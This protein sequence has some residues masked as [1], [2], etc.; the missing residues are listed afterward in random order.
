MLRDVVLKMSYIAVLASLVI[1]TTEPISAC[2]IPMFRYGL[3]AWSSEDYEL[4]VFHKGPMS[5][6]DA[7]IIKN[8]KELQ[9]SAHANFTLHTVD[10]SGKMSDRLQ[11]L[12]KSFKAP[13]LPLLVVKYPPQ[14]RSYR[15]SIWSGHL[16]EDAIRK[17]VDSPARQEIVKRIL[18]GD[19]AV[20]VLVESGDPTK[21]DAAAKFISEELSV[22][23]KELTLSPQLINIAEVSNLDAHIHFSLIG[24]SRDDPAEEVFID[25]LMYSERGLLEVKSSPIVFLVFARGRA[26][27]P[28]VGKGIKEKFIR[29]GC[30][31]VIDMWGED[32][33]ENLGV[34]L[35]MAVDWEAGIGKRWVDEEI[36]L[37]GST[38]LISIAKSD[39]SSDLTTSTSVNYKSEVNTTSNRLLRNIIITILA[40]PVVVIGITLI[41]RPGKRRRIAGKKGKIK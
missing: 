5:E 8:L 13:E 31:F 2:L 14:T 27:T 34:G 4:I 7:L 10:V 29:E 37:V 19:T 35:L 40:I 16:S 39:E 11:N 30:E 23:N 17:I 21:D 12:W 3:E 38:T 32:E 9:L 22:I 28:M 25:M 15:G 6:E 20:L 26:L 24:V 1:L 36:T 18:G 33:P 41:L